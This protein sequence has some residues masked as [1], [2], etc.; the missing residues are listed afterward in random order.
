MRTMWHLSASFFHS[1]GILGMRTMWHLSASFF[2]LF[3]RYCACAQCDTYLPI[4]LSFWEILLMRT[5]WH[6]VQES[7]HLITF[8][9]WRWQTFNMETFVFAKENTKGWGGHS[10]RWFFMYKKTYL[11]LR[12]NISRSCAHFSVSLLKGQIRIPSILRSDP[13]S[14]LIGPTNMKSADTRN[15]IF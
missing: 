4:F 1:F 10:L 8:N 13:N 11:C 5:L 9:I 14:V 2:S 3:G 15:C 7:F 6:F 12:C